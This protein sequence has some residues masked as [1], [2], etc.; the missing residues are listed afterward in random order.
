MVGDSPSN[1]V[2]FGKRAGVGTALLDTGRAHLE[3]GGE[4]GADI[5][6]DSLS[7]ESGV[8]AHALLFPLRRERD[9]KDG[10]F[11]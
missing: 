4:S 11:F 7:L 3:G 9:E 1:D 6:V 2:V 8:H 10:V 5:V